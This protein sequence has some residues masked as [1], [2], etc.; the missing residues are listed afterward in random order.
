ML[1]G[2]CAQVLLAEFVVA[3]QAGEGSVGGVVLVVQGGQGDGHLAEQLRRL[4]QRLVSRDAAAKKYK[5][6]CRSL[7]E[8]AEHLEQARVPRCVLHA[9]AVGGVRSMRHLH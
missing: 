7:K 4:Q 3:S 8:R 9:V 5:D 1:H 6:G 2:R